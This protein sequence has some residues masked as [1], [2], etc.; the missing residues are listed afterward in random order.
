MPLCHTS[1]DMPRV[2]GEGLT[3]ILPED[4]MTRE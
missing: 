1:N 2:A 4:A 3:Y